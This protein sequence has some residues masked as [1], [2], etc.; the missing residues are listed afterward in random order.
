MTRRRPPRLPLP[1]RDGV[2]PSCTGLPHGPWPTIA[3]FLVER[4]PAITRE[5]WLERIEAGDVIDE[6]GVP[7]TAARRYQSPLR[8][9]YYRTLD[10]EA[11]IPFEEQVV[12]RDD[13]LLVVD[14]PPFVPVTPTGKY[15]QESLLVRLK[16]KLK[17]DDLVPMHRI[18][19]ST[20]GLVLF[21]VRPATRG[22][23]QALFPERRIAKHYEAVV[24]W[25]E[26]V[27]SV[28]EIYRSRL[29]D[30]DHFMRVR[31]EP[32]EP[33][34]ETRIE[35]LN[36]HDG[37]ALLRLSPITG[38]KH[39]LRVHCMALGMPIVNDPIYPV[40]L[41]EGAD[42]FGKPLQLLARSLA[43]LDPVTGDLRSFTSPRSLSLTPR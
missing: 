6:H 7:V 41:P 29:V 34:S 31:E 17:L 26:G 10:G 4:F 12:F 1:T 2:G 33:N 9:Y 8:V 40:L 37:Q 27:S 43:F 32:G 24:P 23:Y 42:D 36:V 30:D 14:K 16:R 15:L 11:S 19:R 22:A 3:E 25:S 28:P 38:R 18:D 35:V 20:S 39:Q 13:N 21:S 5:A